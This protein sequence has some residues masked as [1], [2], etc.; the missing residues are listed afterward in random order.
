LQRAKTVFDPYF[1]QTMNL[2]LSAPGIM[3]LPTPL[4]C[5]S[6]AVLVCKRAVAQSLSEQMTSAIRFDL[7][8]ARLAAI[9]DGIT[10]VNCDAKAEGTVGANCDVEVVEFAARAML[11][12]LVMRAWKENEMLRQQQQQQQQQQHQNIGQLRVVHFMG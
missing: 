6:G 7:V 8:A 4:V 2:P 10:R 5:S 9:V 11:G 12:P 3:P 1:Q